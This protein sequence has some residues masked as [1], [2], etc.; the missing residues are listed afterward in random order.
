MGSRPAML[1][2][3][4]NITPAADEDGVIAIQVTEQMLAVIQ[5]GLDSRLFSQSPAS[6][7]GC[8]ADREGERRAIASRRSATES[9]RCI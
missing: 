9:R 2:H 6:S 5:E 8:L 4:R 7:F 3:A 1:A